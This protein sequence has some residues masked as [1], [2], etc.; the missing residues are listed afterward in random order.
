M[1]KKIDFSEIVD[2]QS[3][4]A[5]VD[6]LTMVEAKLKSII[7]ASSK[8]VT[9]KSGGY[10]E[11]VKQV[12]AIDQA[13]TAVDALA[14]AEKKN[15]E[16]KAKLAAAT[17][18][19]NQLL[20]NEAIVAES[21]EGSYNK[22]AAQYN[23]N[24][25]ALNKMSAEQRKATE[26]GRKLE[27][28]TAAIYR[29]MNNLQKATGKY[30]LQVG[31]Y[32]K[33][34]ELATM[35]LGEMRREM[36]ALRQVSFAGKSAEEVAAMKKRIGE[37]TDAMR[38]MKNEMNLLGTENAAIFVSGM[39]FIAASVE[40]VVASLSLFGVE[41]EQLKQV[42]KKM[43]QLI[44]VTQ[45]LSEIEDVVSSGRLKS[46]AVR[47][48]S[49][50]VDTK[51]AIVKWANVVATNAQGKAEAAKAVITGK[52][53]LV[54]KA[55]AAAQWLWNAALAAAGGPMILIAAG[56]AAL[57]AAIGGLIVYLNRSSAANSE[58]ARQAELYSEAT[59]KAVESSAQE[60]VEA[61]ALFEAT[62]KT[63]AGSK[64]RSD[65]IEMINE[66]YGKYLPNLLTEKSSLEDI[67]NAQN[68]VT[69]SILKKAR[70]AAFEERLT[71]LYKEQYKALREMKKDKDGEIQWMDLLKPK[72]Q[73]VAEGYVDIVKAQQEMDD[74]MKLLLK[75][76]EFETSEIDKNTKSVKQNNAE[77]AKLAETEKRNQ[78]AIEA[79]R[80]TNN[81]RERQKAKEDADDKKKLDEK[82]AQEERE[83]L[84]KT[85]DTQISLL[86]QYLKNRDERR[87]RAFDYEID[88]SKKQ[89]DYLRQL[90]AQ[91]S[92]DARN[93]LAFEEQ[94]QA[95]LQARKEKELQR[96]KRV[97]LG[98][99]VLKAYT[100]NVEKYGAD[101][102][103]QKTIKDTI[104][105][106]QLVK[107]LPAFYEGTEDTG[108]GGNM[109]NKGG[110]MAILHP[111]ERVMTAE[112]NAALSG[113]TNWEL[114]NAGL[115]YKQGALDAQKQVELASELKNISRG[116]DKLNEK[117][118]YLGSDYD[119]MAHQVT[120]I[121]EQS[122]SLQ[123]N[124]K[125]LSR[126]D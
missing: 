44:A 90:A 116:I 75:D 21:A 114:V 61:A 121:I 89:Q 82:N 1:A 63:V 3:L 96:Q 43:L 15:A 20:K 48:Q 118:S 25:I 73:Q 122:G 8:S 6:T 70:V 32:E 83:Q 106:S 79:Q 30:V 97:E 35:S 34:A 17:R 109:D 65:A 40:G 105:L 52:A 108:A 88:Q 36:M 51:D 28:E 27:A 101:A 59:D 58:A 110:M 7:E 50:A 72:A 5:L 64:E 113:M 85:F 19:Q 49:M 103:L 104:L 102:A 67:A 26:E 62:K 47:L 77:K 117:P 53:S 125:R 81:D 12:Q 115:M 9:G 23:L 22:L 94:R 60:R 93:N 100:S 80:A 11:I 18:E 16:A 45:A 126:L 74:I 69:A 112:Q 56:V 42:E 66:K 95:E 31:N 46:I 91:G 4:K 92:E 86:D 111:K 78:K 98:L 39:K 87:Q 33:A 37:L 14:E 38:D 76:Y 24:K 124:H 55:A 10:T 41:S 13:T 120:S 57:G 68:L 107:S 123:R 84:A 119:R 2:I 54:T 71:E 99:S 29:E